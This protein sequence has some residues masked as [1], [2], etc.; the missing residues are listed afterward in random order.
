[1]KTKENKNK[2]CRLCKA[3]FEVWA[4]TMDFDSEKEERMRKG[5]SHFCT[6][7]RCLL[8]CRTP[9]KQVA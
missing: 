4:S 3:D 2:E 6:V 7:C 5:L 8:I 9:F 1:M